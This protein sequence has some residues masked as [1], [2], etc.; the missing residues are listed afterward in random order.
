M[1]IEERL[2]KEFKIQILDEKTRDDL[3]LGLIKNGYKVCLH[4]DKKSIN[5]SIAN[6]YFKEDIN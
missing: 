6:Y 1:D 2:T 4:Q 3:I 5:A